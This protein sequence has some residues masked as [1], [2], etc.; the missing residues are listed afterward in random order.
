MT[1]GYLGGG[2]T[3]ATLRLRAY[4]GVELQRRNGTFGSAALLQPSQHRLDA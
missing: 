2:G 3:G 4:A 1:G